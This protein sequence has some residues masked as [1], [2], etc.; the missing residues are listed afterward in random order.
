MNSFIY[1][2]SFKIFQKNEN[3]T[4]LSSSLRTL[5]LKN[6][7]RKTLHLF[8]NCTVIDLELT[9]KMYILYCSSVSLNKK[10][11]LNDKNIQFKFIL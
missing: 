6:K 1:T 8:F 3:N 4:F 5:S 2:L 7:K 10:Q 9:F 11:I